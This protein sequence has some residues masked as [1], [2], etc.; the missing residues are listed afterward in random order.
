MHPSCHIMH[1][2]AGLDGQTGDMLRKHFD[3]AEADEEKQLLRDLAAKIHLCNVETRFKESRKKILERMAT[4]AL[5]AASCETQADAD[6][7]V[8]DVARDTICRELS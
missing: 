6:A 3:G 2:A 7:L 5:D 4:V 1:V 8:S